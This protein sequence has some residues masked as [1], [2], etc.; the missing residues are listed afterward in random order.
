M[1]A[2]ASLM[3]VSCNKEEDPAMTEEQAA[4]YIETSISSSDGGFNEELRK[5]VEL[6]YAEYENN[7]SYTGDTTFTSEYNGVR[8][9]NYTSTMDWFVTC[10][11]LAVSSITFNLNKT[12]NYEGPRLTR[13][14]TTT[15]SITISDLLNTT[16]YTANGSLTSNGSAEFT[17]VKNNVSTTMSSSMTLSNLSVNKTSYE[18]ESGAASVQ[19][20][21]TGN[22]NSA[23]FNASV[24]F[25]GG[26]SADITINGTTYSITIR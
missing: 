7:C 20:D 9:Y 13:Q 11:G 10:D 3:I 26:G 5:V 12:G 22:S 6:A 21:A 1:L 19:I 23:S 4:D 8:S 16:S 14:G 15:G 18:I 24:T 17:G 2:M 25:N